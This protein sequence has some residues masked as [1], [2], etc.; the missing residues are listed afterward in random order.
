MDTIRSMDVVSAVHLGA[1]R[2]LDMVGDVKR[3]LNSSVLP[4]LLLYFH[5]LLA[6]GQ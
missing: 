6:T 4:S 3:R 2:L 1:D 5:C